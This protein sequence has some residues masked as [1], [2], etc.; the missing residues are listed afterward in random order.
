VAAVPN[1]GA[2]ILTFMDIFCLMARF[3]RLGARFDPDEFCDNCHT[4]AIVLKVVILIMGSKK[5]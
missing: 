4:I 2:T 3:R 5:I 1:Y